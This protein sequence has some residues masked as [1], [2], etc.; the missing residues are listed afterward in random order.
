MKKRKP[1]FQTN[2]FKLIQNSNYQNLLNIP[3]HKKQNKSQKQKVISTPNGTSLGAEMAQ[4]L[5]NI[6]SPIVSASLLTFICKL[7]LSRFF[8]SLVHQ[9]KS[10]SKKDCQPDHAV[11]HCLLKGLHQKCGCCTFSRGRFK[12]AINQERYLLTDGALRRK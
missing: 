10:D 2:T 1:Q 5:G 4:T 8:F 7:I 6:S 11:C 12:S 9:R 3:K